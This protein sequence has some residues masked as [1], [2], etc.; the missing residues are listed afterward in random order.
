[1]KRK[2]RHADTFL[3]VPK[4]RFVGPEDINTEP[5][6]TLPEVIT[7]LVEKIKV[8]REEIA[9]AQ[10]YLDQFLRHYP[11]YAHLVPKQAPS[12]AVSNLH[13]TGD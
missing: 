13:R 7:F 11:Q 5:A 2:V 9:D 12:L 4:P 6:A 3:A 8:H 1:M 10:C